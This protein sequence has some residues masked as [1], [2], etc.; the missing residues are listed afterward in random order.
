MIAPNKTDNVI[1]LN[2]SFDVGPTLASNV[3]GRGGTSNYPAG[4][5]YRNMMWPNG[6]IGYDWNFGF[7]QGDNFFGFRFDK[8]D[9][10]HYGYA[11]V[12]FD[13]P[14]KLVT[15]SRWAYNNVADG[16]AHV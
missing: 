2:T 8:P 7:G 1:A 9:G 15:I 11:V 14:N 13:S 6:D 16:I 3:W 4:Y 5:A 12:N 10:M